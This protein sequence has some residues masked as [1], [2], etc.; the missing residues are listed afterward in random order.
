M[1]MCDFYIQLCS[2]QG[3]GNYARRSMI[4][5]MGNLYIVSHNVNILLFKGKA[6]V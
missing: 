1:K 5:F 6:K 2:I 3:W 4:N